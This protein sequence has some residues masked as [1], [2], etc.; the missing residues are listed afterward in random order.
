MKILCIA[1]EE[2]QAYWDYFRPEKLKDVDLI[3]SCGDLKPQYLTFLVTMGHAPLFYVHGNHDTNYERIPP[4]GCECID[5]RVITYR[6]L[7][8]AGF[9]GCLRYRPGDY[10][11]TERQ[12][13]THIIRQAF[14][15]RRGVDIV[16]AHAPV[17][18]HGDLPNHTH[19]GFEAFLT[20][21]ERFRPSYFLHGHVH[22]DYGRNIRRENEYLG[23]KIINVSGTYILEVPDP[24]L[25]AE[26]PKTGIFMR[27]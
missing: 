26:E 4:E 15:L 9:G 24:V 22:M 6:G 13:R 25:P 19:Q 7:R 16:V 18:N 3:L 2:S 14:R 8:I 21:I 23:T 20:L 5:D 17:R 12:M 10:Q 27:R 1:D 11:Y